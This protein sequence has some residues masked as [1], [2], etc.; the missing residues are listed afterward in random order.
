METETS[1][2]ILGASKENLDT[3]GIMFGSDVA[4]DV[5]LVRG[6]METASKVAELSHESMQHNLDH[7]VELGGDDD[8]RVR[9]V[10]YRRILSLINSLPWRLRPESDFTPQGCLLR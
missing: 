6:T 10:L 2:L 4:Q 8:L 9:R 1:S 7:A 3:L 5:A